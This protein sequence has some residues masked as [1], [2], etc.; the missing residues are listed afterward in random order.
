MPWLGELSHENTI[1]VPLFEKTL[2]KTVLITTEDGDA[3][4]SEVYMY[5]ADS[6]EDLLA[7]NGQLYVFRAKDSATF[8]TWDDIYFS[9]GSV[10]GKFIPLD[11]DHAIQDEIDLHNEALAKGAFLFVRPEDA[12][13]D[14]R[15]L[16]GNIMY[17]AD[18]G[19][20][21]DENGVLIPPGSNGQEFTKGRM[22]KFE[23]TDPKDPTTARFRVMMDGNDPKAPGF[24]VLVNPDN[25][26]TSK[27]SLMINEDW[28]GVNRSPAT[29]TPYDIT[30][31]SKILRVDLGSGKLEKVAFVNQL[32]IPA[33]VHGNWESSGILDAS[34][35][36]G[37]GS[38]LV[39]VQAHGL[40]EGGQ[41]LLMKVRGS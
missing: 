23:F 4:D 15:A 40:A 19:N 5:I 8:N 1:H 33:L 16:R 31:N 26:D 39:D 12:A 25:I 22:Y 10:K 41:L 34:E 28:I 37:R 35:F 30:K 2:G 29:E 32:E 7:G 9:T 11:W 38:W 14:K 18:T 13:M 3:T 17:M 36:F 21:R 24:G 6:P 27:R 20:D